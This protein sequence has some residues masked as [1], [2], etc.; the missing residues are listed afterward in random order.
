MT[1]QTT[2][3]RIVAAISLTAGVSIR[4]AAKHLITA[5]ALLDKLDL[6]TDWLAGM[7]QLLADLAHELDPSIT[8]YPEMD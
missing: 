2:E 8:P 3:D 5:K 4:E 6:S 7:Y 1:A